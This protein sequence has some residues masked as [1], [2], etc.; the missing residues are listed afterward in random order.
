MLPTN[1]AKRGGKS[2]FTNRASAFTS[3][4][5]N[6]FTL[7]ELLVVIAI[8]AILAAI[9]FP[10]F[11]RARDKARQVSCLSNCK[12][13]AQAVSMWTQDHD[14]FLPKATFNDYVNT[15]REQ[16]PWLLCRYS[17]NAVCPHSGFTITQG[18]IEDIEGGVGIT[19]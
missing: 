16:A 19:V 9:L 1:A 11:A 3:V 6:A 10:V 18:V 13:L 12:Q 14:E 5:S 4:Q 7:I 8:I 17:D 15:P 2:A